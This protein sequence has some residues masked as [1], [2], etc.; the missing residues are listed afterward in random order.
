M[1]NHVWIV[2][3]KE[4]GKWKPSNMEYTKKAAVETMKG[5]WLGDEE[6]LRVKKYE[7]AK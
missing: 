1:K 2:E 7:A 5:I 4:K 6:Y 3:I